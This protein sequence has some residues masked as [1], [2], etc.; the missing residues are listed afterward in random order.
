MF[1]V[2]ITMMFTPIV[3]VIASHLH[4][5]KR[6]LFAMM[7]MTV[8]GCFMFSFSD[9]IA[10]YFVNSREEKAFFL[11]YFGLVAF[12]LVDFTNEMV[13]VRMLKFSFIA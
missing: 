10:L 2:I 5:K 8:I 4:L 9:A 1:P 6:T 12:V 11:T 3:E 7:T 13:L